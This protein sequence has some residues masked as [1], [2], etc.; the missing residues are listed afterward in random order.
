MVQALAEVLGREI[1]G[2]GCGKAVAEAG[3][4]GGGVLQSLEVAGIGHERGLCGGVKLLPGS[5][6]GVPIRCRNM[7][8]YQLE[9]RC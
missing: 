2:N 4:G 6:Q 9:Q 7:V 8:Y 1:R 5:G 3:K